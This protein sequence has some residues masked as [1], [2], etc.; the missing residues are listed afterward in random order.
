MSRQERDTTVGTPR[1]TEPGVRPD[2]VPGATRPDVIPGVARER[3]T[4]PV[5]WEEMRSLLRR[6]PTF[7][8]RT[9][10][11]TVGG[12]FTIIAGAFNFLSGIGVI[13]AANSLSTLINNI[14]TTFGTTFSTTVGNAYIPAAA[15]LMVLGILS[16]VGGAF[17][18]SRRLWGVSFAGSIAALFPSPLIL[19][20]LMGFF[21]LIFITLGHPEFRPTP[22]MPM[23]SSM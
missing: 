13:Q 16:I 18:Q 21:A 9:W 3:M 12:I 14:N 17:A 10:R 22:R 15:V 11:P 7:Y 19:P 6:E 1:P 5:T 20:F 23:K 4:G 8:E 2:T